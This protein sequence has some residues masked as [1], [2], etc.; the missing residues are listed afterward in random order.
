MEKTKKIT[1]WERINWILAALFFLVG[2]I[3]CGVWFALAG[4]IVTI[5]FSDNDYYN[6][7]KIAEVSEVFLCNSIIVATLGLTSTLWIGPIIVFVYSARRVL[8]IVLRNKMNPFSNNNDGSLLQSNM[9]LVLIYCFLLIPIFYIG[10]GHHTRYMEVKNKYED[11]LKYPYLQSFLTNEERQRLKNPYNAFYLD[12]VL[13]SVRKRQQET[14]ESLKHKTDSLIAVINAQ[15]QADFQKMRER[16]KGRVETLQVKRFWMNGKSLP[17]TWQAYTSIQMIHK[18]SFLGAKSSLTIDGEGAYV[19]EMR[20]DY[21]N[22]LF[23][24]NSY[25]RFNIKDFPTW[26]L[27]RPQDKVERCYV[28]RKLP[29][30]ESLLNSLNQKDLDLA[31]DKKFVPLLKK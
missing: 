15:K 10:F 22:V 12:D 14:L 13:A 3:Y 1:L 4:I 31:F 7:P 25:Q 8:L 5:I 24:D 27:I 17:W 11:Y 23:S 30:G 26:I 29:S 2:A 21:V 19:G 18:P 28:E 16:Y 9:S 20:F 6:R